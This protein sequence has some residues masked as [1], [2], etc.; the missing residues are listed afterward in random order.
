MFRKSGARAVVAYVLLVCAT[1]G[2]SIVIDSRKAIGVAPF[3]PS[4]W[5]LVFE[6]NFD[7]LDVSA[8]GP[9]TRWIA[10]T[11]WNGDFGDAQFVDPEPGFPFT[12]E[13]GILRIEARKAPDGRWRSGLL[14]AVGPDG[15]GFLP[16]FGYYEMRAKLPKGEG[17]WPAFWTVSRDLPEYSIE[18]DTIEHYGHFPDSFESVIHFWPR[19]DTPHRSQTGV[20]KVPSGS[21][22][23]D[24]NTY[25]LLVEKDWTRI[26]L[27]RQEVWKSPTPP[28]HRGE[29]HVLV[30][31]AMGSGWPTVNSPDPSFLYVDYV[32]VWRA[33]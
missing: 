11:P 1:F 2:L 18:F 12:T 15:K 3:D 28:E 16:A 14:A 31:L 29:M 25:G 4:S 5:Q 13:N 8:W 33:P 7:K 17:L 10:H 30:N 32:R 6:E 22:Y 24:F 9:G 26:Y 19:N 27:N 23:K 21:L 20:I